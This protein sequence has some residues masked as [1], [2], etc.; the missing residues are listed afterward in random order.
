[1][2]DAHVHVWQIDRPDCAWPGAD[3]PALNRN[4]TLGEWRAAAAGAR[5][6]LVQTQTCESDTLWLL[7]QARGDVAGVIGWTDLAA[8]DAPA[9]IDRLRTAGPLVG[10]RPMVQAR[11]DDW[12]DD[13]T[14][15]DG[16][17]YVAECGLVLDALIQPRHLPSLARLAARHPTLKIVIDHAAKPVIGSDLAEWAAGMQTL[18]SY[19]Q[20]ACKLSGL[21]TEI[22]DGADDV[23]RPYIRTLVELFGPQR[24]IWGSDWPVVTI[25]SSYA[26]W[27]DLARAAVPATQHAAVF[28]GNAARIYG[29]ETT[30]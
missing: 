26:G 24:L 17:A 14:L 20:V 3:L 22:A 23:V 29:L 4:F 8:D 30:A 27:L 11:A 10:V 1:M 2:I 16:L 19:P 21:L 12:Y 15:D 6:I 5:A 7:S 25:R 18:A 13:A 9:A 28:G